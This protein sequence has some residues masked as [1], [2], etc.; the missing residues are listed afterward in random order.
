M[1][2]RKKMISLLLVCAMAI[3][4][5]TVPVKAEESVSCHSQ[6][7]TEL[8]TS[9][10]VMLNEGLF[11]DS[12][13]IGEDY[14]LSYDVERLAVS[15]FRYSSKRDQAPIDMTN[16]Y[17][18]WE[19]SGE[20]GLGGHCFGHYMSACVAMYRQTGNEQLKKN[21]ERGV[22][23]L[24][25]A[26]DEDGFVAGFSRNN[27]DYVFANPDT[28][29]AGGN[30]SAFL[31]G[32][33]APWYTIHKL[34]AGLI[35][36]Y[37]Y[38]GIEDALVYAEKIA[39]YAKQGT[40]KLNAAQMEKMLIGEHGGIN[41]SFAQL[42]EITGEE[43]YIELAKRFSHKAIMDPLSR[44]ENNLPGLHANTQIPKIVGAA[45]IYLLTGD[46][47]YKKVCENF[48]KYVVETQTYAN[49]GTS[50]YEFFTET[51]EEPL[52][53][54]N[55]ETCCVYNMLKLTEYMYQW[56][57]SSEY[58]DY[59]ENVLYN[60]ILGSQNSEGRK[61]YSVDLS[62]G[63]STVFLGREGFECC[64]G[65]GFENPARYSRMIYAKRADELDV[66]LFINS[67]V[68][69]KEKG[70]TLTQKTEYPQ[71]D[72][73]KITI[74]QA[75][76]KNAA[77]RIRVPFWT[78]GMKAS[79]N[80]D[81]ADVTPENEYV[82]LERVWKKN[83]VIELTVPMYLRLYVARSDVHK[84][85]FKY[86]PILLAGDLGVDMVRSIVTD[87]Q[88]PEKFIT[89]TGDGLTF[90]IDGLLKPGNK[91]ITL[92]PFYEF[93]SEP[94]MAYWNLYTTEEYESMSGLNASFAERLEEVTID[95]VTPGHLQSELDHN[96][97]STGYTTN[98]IYGPAAI[99]PANGS[100]R[101]VSGGTIS[102]DLKVDGEAGNYLV[103]MFW[104]SDNHA[105]STRIFD[106]LVEDTVLQE[107][108][109]LN[110]NLPGEIE[111]FYLWIPKELTKGKDKVTVTYRAD[112]GKVAGGVF[113]VRTTSRKVGNIIWDKMIGSS[114]P[115]LE[116][117]GA[118]NLYEGEGPY[119]NKEMYTTEKEACVSYKFTGCSHIRLGAKLDGEKTGADV[120][121]DG[122]KVTFVKTQSS[123]NV[124]EI[125]WESER[126]NPDEEHELK[127]VNTGSFGFD[128]L[129]TGSEIIK[130]G[131]PEQEETE[132]EPEPEPV[133]I[134]Y[135][136][137]KESDWFYQAVKF[138]YA[139]GI[140]T[141][142]DKTHF[143]P[144]ENLARAQFAVILHRMNDAPE[145]EY[146]AKFPD[147]PGN[148]WFTDAVLWAASTEVVKGYSD[149]G[150]FG[151]ADN[152]N[153]EQ[154]AVMMYRYA[155]YKEYDVSVYQDFSKFT[156]A[157]SVNEFAKDAMSW[158]VGMG[159]ITGKDN[160]TRL[161]PQGNASRAECAIIM[162]RFIGIYENGLE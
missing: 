8:F 134:P 9:D 155:K 83:D 112:S 93:E 87:E 138:N 32:I 127:I 105:N 151:P 10:E 34:L 92:K 136:D 150:K 73:I 68:T 67:S 31:Q 53:D 117:G 6:E 54:K 95:S 39:S 139:A 86:G 58:M 135:E 12:Q 80:G 128:Y 144:Y 84:V 78:D 122:K 37:E 14:L 110:N 38:M 23:L 119:E 132:P 75:S 131:N 85:A 111:Y 17:G 81:D 77:I 28:F 123:K 42:Y 21:V 16:G 142:T 116:Y 149:S 33:W 145:V 52:S 147:V 60:Q 41:E 69:W 44:G 2:A 157:S 114:S 107:S 27:L 88:S 153:R 129:Q 25:I 15:L 130:L 71:E 82:T 26:Q 133:E 98:G 1:K 7:E 62:M 102:Y 113:G 48:W 66:N 156:D 20:N 45:K 89:K 146:A 4:L 154:M 63:A 72:T 120:Y 96:Y 125:V 158:A 24:G 159:I 46:E 126:L 94:H 36:A 64:M 74:D 97:Q 99:A 124:Y 100:W 49:G 79:V 13:K 19:N 91:S 101:D 51:D 106:I 161:D 29:W 118:W 141:G 160:G 40:D 57:P 35:D 65:T 148:T 115:D 76:G 18:G 11:L 140:M 90:V 5:A 59:Y 22:E 61:T 152:I 55:C 43:K 103:S 162:Q 121:L 30:N 108:Y 47:Y 56:N 50:N 70:I 104:G 143:A 137:I 109:E 3:G